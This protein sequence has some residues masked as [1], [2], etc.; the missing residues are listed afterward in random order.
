MDANVEPD[1][2]YVDTHLDIATHRH[3]R[4]VIRMTQIEVYLR[5]TL[6]QR[7]PRRTGYQPDR[8]SRLAEV[9]REN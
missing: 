6:D 9:L 2:F 5:C 7:L 1:C 3:Q 8:V 4:D